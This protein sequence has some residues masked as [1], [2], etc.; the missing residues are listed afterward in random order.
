MR[1]RVLVREVLVASERAQTWLDEGLEVDPGM[2]VGGL[3]LRLAPKLSGLVDRGSR[4][5]VTLGGDELGRPTRLGD[6]YRDG[7]TVEVWV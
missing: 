6:V 3:L 1:L 5:F 7:D 2:T 4:P